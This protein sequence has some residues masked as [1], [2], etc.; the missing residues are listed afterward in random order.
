MG[1][2][3]ASK[4]LI[5]TVTLNSA[6]DKTYMVENYTLDRVHRPY[7]WRR[8]SQVGRASTSP[9]CCARWKAGSGTGFVGGYNGGLIVSELDEEG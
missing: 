2:R 9:A 3:R 1:S 7:P 8:A 4:P 5:V 6:V